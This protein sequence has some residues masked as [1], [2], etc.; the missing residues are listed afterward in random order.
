[1]VDLIRRISSTVRH[2]SHDAGT[3]NVDEFHV[4]A[5]VAN[6]LDERNGTGYVVRG[7]EVYTSI[8]R[9]SIG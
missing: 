7:G 1:M 9:E 6:A 8:S 2:I 3:G 5:A 4:F